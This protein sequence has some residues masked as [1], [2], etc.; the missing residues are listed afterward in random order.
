[1]GSV[2]RG[3]SRTKRKPPKKPRSQSKYRDAEYENHATAATLEAVR[4]RPSGGLFALAKPVPHARSSIRK[5]SATAIRFSN[6]LMSARASLGLPAERPRTEGA[7]RH[8]PGQSDGRKADG[9]PP[10][11]HARASTKPCKGETAWAISGGDEFNRSSHSIIA[12]CTIGPP[13]QGA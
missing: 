5:N 2:G 13:F 4:R 12:R 11:D 8:S 10:R 3:P 1:M 6:R 9:A 7:T